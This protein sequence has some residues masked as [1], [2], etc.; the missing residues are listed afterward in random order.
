M[1]IDI[2]W[3]NCIRPTNGTIELIIPC[4]FGIRILHLALSDDQNRFVVFP[5][6]SDADHGLWRLYGG[7][8]FWIAP[9]SDLSKTPDND[10]VQIK[11]VDNG[12]R[13]KQITD[14]ESGL[15]KKLDVILHPDRP[16]V[17]IR[18][19]VQNNGSRAHKLAPW[20]I[21]ALVP[22]GLGILPLPRPISEHDTLM[23]HTR[24]ALWPYTN[25]GLGQFSFDE[26]FVL[27][28]SPTKL[29]QKIGLSCEDG[30]CA[31]LHVG[32]LF[33]KVF[34]HDPEANYPDQGSSAE[35]YCDRQLI[36]LETLG[37]LVNCPGGAIVEQTETWMLCDKI[38]VVHDLHAFRETVFPILK[39]C[40]DKVQD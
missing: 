16:Q 34:H 27:L 37:P 20:G 39:G 7:Y 11:E 30:W 40:L 4:N 1:Q 8:R 10:P 31:Y 23:A 29:P 19:C 18:H 6:G 26:Q 3:E 5:H 36:E 28:S 13:V 33:I 32:Q 17:T 25:L 24:I 9:E 12:V 14:V 22:D 15:Q 38:P 2:N 35:L 21:T